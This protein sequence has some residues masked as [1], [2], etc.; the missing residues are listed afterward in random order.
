M[1]TK[2]SSKNDRA[3]RRRGEKKLRRLREAK[4][5]NTGKKYDIEILDGDSSQI[6][7]RVPAVKEGLKLIKAKDED[8]LIEENVKKRVRYAAMHAHRERA[9]EVLALGGSRKMA[10]RRAGV[11][12]R[13][14]QKYFSDPDFRERIQELQEMV[15]SKIRGRVMKEVTRR[16]GPKLIEKI[17]LLDLLRI[18][19]RFGLGRG[20]ASAINVS[21][22]EINNYESIFNSVFLGDTEQPLDSEE[23]GADFPAFEPSRLAL[24]GGDSPVEG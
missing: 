24:S 17:E 8:E 3:H 9:A 12:T 19:D 20:N 14:I 1:A 5:V 6:R 21:K 23:E 2:I 7:K 11:S 10:A 18:G 4:D 22:T 13:Q 16:T 15:G